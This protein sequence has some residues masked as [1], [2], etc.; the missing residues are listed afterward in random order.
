MGD[1]KKGRSG[2]PMRDWQA[3]E[4]WDWQAAGQRWRDRGGCSGSYT[5]EAVA[6]R[7]QAAWV[8]FDWKAV[9][10]AVKA[11]VFIHDAEYRL[12]EVNQAYLERAGMTRDQV[13]GRP[14]WE[15]FPQRHGPLP[16]CQHVVEG[17]IDPV[18]RSGTDRAGAGFSYSAGA[19][20]A[21]EECTVAS[22]ESLISRSFPVYGTDGVY[23]HSL[24]ILEDVTAQR[25]S[26]QARCAAEAKAWAFAAAAQDAI[27][28]SDE[29]QR[30][31]FCNPAAERLLGYREAELLTLSLTEG[32]GLCK[33]APGNGWG[34]GREAMVR[35]CNGGQIPVA[36]SMASLV[37]EGRR[38]EVRILH[39]LRERE[40][41][42]RVLCERERQLDYLL[43]NTTEGILVIN[44]AGLVLYANATAGVLFD[45]SAEEL[46]G[47]LFGIPVARDTPQEIELYNSGRGVRTVEMRVREL[48]WEGQEA[49]L[50]NLH[51]VT[52]RK[53]VEVQLRQAAIFFD[54]AAEGIMITDAQQRIVVVNRAFTEITGYSAEE[55]R[56]QTPAILRSGVH[57]P[58]FYAALWEALET[59]GSWSGEVWNR[60]RNG[61]TY[62]QQLNIREVR[63]E[64][65]HRSHFMAVFSDISRVKEYQH[66]LERMMHLDPLTGLPNRMLFHD[67][68]E[69]A[70]VSSQRTG[71]LLAV[72]IVDVSD[73]KL[74]NDSFGHAVGDETLEQLAERL[75]EVVRTEDTVA[76]LGGDEFGVLMPDLELVDEVV[77]LTE[78][79]MERL[80]C[81]FTIRGVEMPVS[82]RIGLAV[83]PDQASSAAELIQQADAA[84]YQAKREEVPYR[85]FS[86]ELT[87][88]ARERVELAAELRQA[89]ANDQLIVYYQ[90]Q[91]GLHDGRW[92]GV[93][94]LVRWSHPRLGWVSPARFVPVA[95]SSGLIV[96]LGD[97]VLAQAARQFRQWLDCG[98]DLGLL[99]VNFAAPQLN[100]TDVV[101]KTLA[102]L[103]RVGLP[104]DR[105][106]IEVTERLLVDPDGDITQRL[107]QLR[108]HGVR[109]AIDDFG[110]GYSS[111]SYL[112]DLPVDL[113]KID[114][115]FVDG[116]PEDPHQSAIV[117][118]IIALGRS[119]G[120]DVLAEGI[121]SEAQRAALLAEGCERGQGFYFARPADSGQLMATHRERVRT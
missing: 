42:A 56:G 9:I 52:E 3:V 95:E 68:L 71:C 83:Y 57:G 99:G 76:R 73:F 69:Q 116:L 92:N 80:H 82:T 78:A 53:R 4:K 113:L 86:Q 61:D 88:R 102:T 74:I 111:L 104:P 22:G 15:V 62:A 47:L 101:T 6:V 46:L 1:E 12:L 23:R 21:V 8:G 103:E 37:L 54:E 63:D 115:S 89:L 118:A 13:L 81:P 72:L 43:A 45:C 107:Q 64:S 87:E 58:E 28:L 14:Y 48:Q 65:G 75:S 19:A 16:G 36:V 96:Q 2:A 26:E 10:D 30:V 117:R 27:L 77:T 114:R 55:V 109:V 24:H 60:R 34:R 20:G 40:A 50:L 33:T 93:E 91:V 51:D 11:L 100:A 121:E 97:W 120:F 5:V 44:R 29:Q 35:H 32:L 119:L 79:L 49:Q 17:G 94:A 84:M 7:E 90:P 41:A 85:F 38:H 106:E 31:V 67:R 66:Q 25:Q 112:K 18:A 110:T 98:L 39:D 59:H 105:L 70:L 108:A